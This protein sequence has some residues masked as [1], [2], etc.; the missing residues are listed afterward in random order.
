MGVDRGFYRSQR[1][2]HCTR[3]KFSFLVYPSYQ[4]PRPPCSCYPVSALSPDL[5]IVISAVLL[6]HN[7]DCSHLYSRPFTSPRSI[8]RLILSLVERSRRSHLPT[9]RFVPNARP[10]G[11]SR[12]QYRGPD[13]ASLALP[14]PPPRGC[15]RV[16]TRYAAHHPH[17]LTYPSTPMGVIETLSKNSR[18]ESSLYHF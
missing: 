15:F 12:D 7:Y 16:E 18:S 5:L 13:A 11:E 4:Y 1:I 9:L 17:L 6:F 8:W 3:L 14:L 10:R 2:L